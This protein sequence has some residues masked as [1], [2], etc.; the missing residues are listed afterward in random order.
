MH[1]VCRP[2]KGVPLPIFNKHNADREPM[3]ETSTVRLTTSVK[4]AFSRSTDG[5]SAIW[6][7]RPPTT[8]DHFSVGFVRSRTRT[9]AGPVILAIASLFN[10]ASRNFDL[11]HDRRVD[12]VRNTRSRTPIRLRPIVTD[13]I[14]PSDTHGGIQAR[15][16]D[17]G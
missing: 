12:R 3:L 1:L 7:F 11:Q 9:R 16:T 4:Q 14:A 2:L 5:L 10:P 17:G 6:S 15:P 13:T 8:L